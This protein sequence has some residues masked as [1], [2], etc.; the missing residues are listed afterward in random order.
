M[1][2]RLVTKAIINCELSH[3]DREM[4]GVTD[5]TTNVIT[6]RIIGGIMGEI[7]GGIVRPK[8]VK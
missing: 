6:D 8:S 7:M 2:F 4:D 1:S 5:G 3:K